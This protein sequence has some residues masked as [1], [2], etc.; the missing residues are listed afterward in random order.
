MRPLPF[1]FPYAAIFWVAFFW[2]FGREAR[3]IRRAQKATASGGAPDDSGS[4]RVVM[5]TQGLGF[6]AAFSF[7]WVSRGRYADPRIAFW[8]GMTMLMGGALLR[9]LCFRALGAS[10]TGEVRVRRDQRLIAAGPY[11]WVRHPSYTAGILMI[12]GVATAL[13]SWVGTVIAFG[14]ALAGYA[15]RVRIEERALTATLGDSYRAYAAATKRF[16]PFVI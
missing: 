16:I 13:G 15:Y 14:L 2:A 5:L 10:F 1:V 8:I 7:A 12:T 6:A 11:R 3:V 9:R 4:L